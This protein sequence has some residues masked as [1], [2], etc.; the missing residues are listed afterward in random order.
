MESQN[1]RNISK[2]QQQSVLIEIKEGVQYV[3]SQLNLI[4][5]AGN[6]FNFCFSIWHYTTF[7]CLC[8]YGK[9]RSCK[10]E[11]TGVRCG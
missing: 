10:R 11:D 8:H 3:L 1:V 6:M 5:L 7:R 4:I 9:I 2:E